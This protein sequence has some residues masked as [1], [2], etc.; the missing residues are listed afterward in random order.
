MK[1][2]PELEAVMSI[3]ETLTPLMAHPLVRVEYQE[4][5]VLDAA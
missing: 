3:V 2:N 1:P 5:G 4:V